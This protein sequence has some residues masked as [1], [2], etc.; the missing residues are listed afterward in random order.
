MA[1]FLENL[2]KQIELGE[3]NYDAQYNPGT[4]LEVF[5][6]ASVETL[7]LT[8][9]SNKTEMLLKSWS[10]FITEDDSLK[11]ALEYQASYFGEKVP[12]I[13][14]GYGSYV[15]L[16]DAAYQVGLSTIS[17]IWQKPDEKYDEEDSLKQIASIFAGPSG[18]STESNI[19]VAELSTTEFQGYSLANMSNSSDTT[20][21]L[22]PFQE[23]AQV[24]ETI[25]EPG[26]AGVQLVI[27]APNFS[28]DSLID[29]A[30]ILEGRKEREKTFTEKLVD[31]LFN[32]VK[33]K[34]EDNKNKKPKATDEESI[35]AK[36]IRNK[37]NKNLFTVTIRTYASSREV[38]L[39]LAK[40]I[41]LRSKSNYQELE[42][43]SEE[44]NLHNLAIRKTGY[45]PCLLS[46]DEIAYLWHVPIASDGGSKLHKPS[47]A[48]TI[49]PE[50][51]PYIPINTIDN[52]EVLLKQEFPRINTKK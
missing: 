36:D 4:L 13:E 43:V 37:A 3:A 19:S 34:K 40:I 30:L 46:S 14:S 23:L 49:P 25:Q 35:R 20:K 16:P 38:C 24:F 1:T 31:E 9:K 12:S 28:Y 11:F 51:L 45:K 47:I 29:E 39:L 33:G 44:A 42:I 5:N 48:A 18:L 7:K 6:P 2:I 27:E 52:I 26:F 10:G 15:F 17:P 41:M 21:L 32:S 50:G 22:D 8:D